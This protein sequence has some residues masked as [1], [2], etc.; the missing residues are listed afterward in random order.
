MK[1][2]V[3]CCAFFPFLIFSNG[4]FT[5]EIFVKTWESSFQNLIN[6]LFLQYFL[7]SLEKLVSRTLA[8][9]MH[10]LVQLMFNILQLRP[11]VQPIQCNTGFTQVQ[12]VKIKHFSNNQITKRSWI[13]N[14]LQLLPFVLDP[15]Q[16]SFCGFRV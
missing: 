11:Y 6:I 15:M 5:W 9:G 10:W 16:W 13:F 3:S 2:S 8:A 1:W 4:Y 7:F 12:K 14:I